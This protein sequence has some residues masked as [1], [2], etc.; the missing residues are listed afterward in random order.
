MCV[1]S[2]PVKKR[3][4]TFRGI[5]HNSNSVDLM[6]KREANKSRKIDCP[7]FYV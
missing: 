3:F 5:L 4:A 2:I 7:L 1:N 6:N